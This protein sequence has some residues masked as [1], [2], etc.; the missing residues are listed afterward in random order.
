[1]IIFE[2][3]NLHLFKYKS[4]NIG[5]FNEYS[6]SDKKKYKF[7]NKEIDGT[8]TYLN[9]D[10]E[11]K[12]NENMN[13]AYLEML[14]KSDTSVRKDA[15]TFCSVVVTLPEQLKESEMKIQKLFFEET[16]KALDDFFSYEGINKDNVSSCFSCP[17]HLDETTPHMHYVFVPFD[18]SEVSVNNRNADL[19]KKVI[20]RPNA[21]KI[22]SKLKLKQLHPFVEDYLKT[23]SIHLNLFQHRNLLFDS[24]ISNEEREQ[25]KEDYK[26]T[27]YKELKSKTKEQV[28]IVGN[29]KVEEKNL[30]KSL[31]ELQVR[32]KQLGIV[33][34]SLEE[35]VIEKNIELTD[36]ITCNTDMI[37][38]RNKLY[39]EVIYN[40]QE[41][42]NINKELDITVKNLNTTIKEIDD[43]VSDWDYLV[44]AKITPIKLKLASLLEVSPQVD[45][46][47]L[48]EKFREYI[49]EISTRELVMNNKEMELIDEE[50]II[51]YSAMLHNG[52]IECEI[53]EELS[54]ELNNDRVRLNELMQ[55]IYERVD[56]KYETNAVNTIENSISM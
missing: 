55:L 7:E 44:E 24:N 14:S 13:K 10:L 39:E 2:R 21:K 6:R 8:R 25:R 31:G 35:K 17:V 56:I 43:K 32:E 53:M 29:L 16:K 54:F 41:L 19:G 45:I 11:L 50:I 26:D 33:I 49:N 20:L 42:E 15:V 46:V 37:K 52:M 22:T 28:K 1:M 40:K 34:E 18:K 12:K 4:S 27:D 51:R 30:N 47:N 3:S 38:E 48:F 36:K 5:I 23:K 9:Y